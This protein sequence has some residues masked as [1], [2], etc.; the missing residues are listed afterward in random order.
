MD[1]RTMHLMHITVALLLLVGGT[2]VAHGQGAASPAPA[3]AMRAYVDPV[4]GEF[5]RPLAPPAAEP[6]R[7]ARAVDSSAALKEVPGTTPAGG[8]LVR[9]PAAMGHAFVATVGADG[10]QSTRCQTASGDGGKKE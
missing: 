6:S 4:T 5:G 2:G 10:T 9:F 8:M 7:A 3:A 1:E